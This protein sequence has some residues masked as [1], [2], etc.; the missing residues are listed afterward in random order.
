MLTMLMMLIGDNA[1]DADGAGDADNNN[2][3]DADCQP[4]SPQAASSP[5][6]PPSTE[7]ALCVLSQSLGPGDGDVEDGGDVKDEDVEEEDDDDVKEEGGAVINRDPFQQ[8][9][10]FQKSELS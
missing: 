4:V 8:I 3:V 6:R 10:I 5:T 2:A 1:A 9:L 7:Q